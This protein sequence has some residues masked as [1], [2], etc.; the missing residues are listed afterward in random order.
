M[1]EIPAQA[2]QTPADRHFESSPLR[3]LDEPV[4]RRPAILGHAH[5]V[6]NEL[7]RATVDVL[8]LIIVSGPCWTHAVGCSRE[9]EDSE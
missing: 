8:A 9:S 5:T 2:V 3:V 4:Q 7:T 1:A 6:V